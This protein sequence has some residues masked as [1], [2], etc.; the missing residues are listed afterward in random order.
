MTASEHIK[1][2]LANKTYKLSSAFSANSFQD[3]VKD[4]FVAGI[5]L[6]TKDQTVKYMPFEIYV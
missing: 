6:P 2:I 4:E 1:A 5:V 3:R